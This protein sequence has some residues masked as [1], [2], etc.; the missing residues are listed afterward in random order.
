MHLFI[1]INPE[2]KDKILKVFIFYRIILIINI[3]DYF[4]YNEISILII[5]IV[6]DMFIFYMLMLAKFHY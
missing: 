1:S 3:R 4:E 5:I 2:I 6:L